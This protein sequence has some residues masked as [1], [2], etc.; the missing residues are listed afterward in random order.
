MF[1]AEGS[2]WRM[3]AL[4]NLKVDFFRFQ[5]FAL[6]GGVGF[7]VDAG[8]LHILSMFMEVYIA[9]LISLVFAITTTW[10]LNR[11][12]TFSFREKNL[13][14]EY[15][16]YLFASKFSAGVNYLSFLFFFYILSFGSI[17]SLIFATSIS[18][19][20]NFYFYKKI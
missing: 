5:R 10:S 11:K 6:V 15:T 13:F 17:F 8:I 16:K 20:L 4:E 19:F 9:R 7:I 12:F 1:R 14:L 3:E 18:M 2:R